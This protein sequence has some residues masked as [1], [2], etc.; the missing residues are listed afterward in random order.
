MS[1][2]KAKMHQIGF[3]LGLRPRPSGGAYS[4]SPDSTAVVKGATSKKGEEKEGREGKGR[5]REG[6]GEGEGR[7]KIGRQRGRDLPDQCQTAS[8]SPVQPQ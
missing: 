6:E 2:F 3:P 5:E 8:Y 4:A 1:D 7:G